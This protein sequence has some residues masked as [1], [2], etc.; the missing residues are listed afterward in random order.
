MTQHKKTSAGIEKLKTSIRVWWKIDGKRYRETLY[1]T[2]PTVENCNHAKQIAQAIAT[3]LKLGTFDRDRMFPNSPKRKESYY[4]YYIEK[5]Q[6][7]E[8]NRV[9]TSSWNTYQSKVNNHI[10]DYWKNKQIAKITVEDIEEWV[11]NTLIKQKDLSTK[12]IQEILTLWQKIWSY[13]A[14]HQAHANNPAQYIKLNKKDPDDIDPFNKKEIIIITQMKTADPMLKNLWTV[15]LWSGLSTHELL[16]LA[17]ED[18][19]LEKGIAY[20]KRGFVK[21]NYRVTKNR[22]RKRQI[23]LL[24]IVI[25]ALHAQI[26]LVENNKPQ[27]I[28]IMDRDHRTHKTQTLTFL[29]CETDNNTHLSYSMLEKRWKK[30]LKQ[31]DI[32]YRPPNN[33][34]HTYASQVLSTGQ[35]TAEWLAKQLGHTSTEM[36]HKHYGKFIPEDSLHIIHQL[37]NALNNT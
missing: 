33:G 18:L 3:Q 6:N 14:R 13:W 31:C 9:A 16:P 21:G 20:I 23:E 30:H 19:E 32:R 24:P 2:S 27:T 1:N 28:K 4:G 11:Y 10:K 29:W 17:V 5:W 37:N 34:R 7:V 22:R 35:I 26:K 12:T 36:I 15:M 25:E 8:Q